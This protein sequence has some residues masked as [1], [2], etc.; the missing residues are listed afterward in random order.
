M[1]IK[2][3]NHC[4]AFLFCFV[5]SKNHFK[6]KEYSYVPPQRRHEDQGRELLRDYFT[7][8][9]LCVPCV[10]IKRMT[11]CPIRKARCFSGAIL[12]HSF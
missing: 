9:A 4:T 3:A 10:R 8:D 12:R 11:H 2:C 5:F 1:E 6:G 7:M